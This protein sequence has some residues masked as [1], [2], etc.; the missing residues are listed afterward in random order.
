MSVITQSGESALILAVVNGH[1]EVAVE[2]VKA[3]TNLDLQNKVCSTVTCVP[4]QL[5]HTPSH[6]VIIGNW[7]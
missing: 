4:Y 6:V 1:T 3:E 5:A 7:E 2:L